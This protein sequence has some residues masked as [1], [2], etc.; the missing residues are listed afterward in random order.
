MSQLTNALNNI[1]SCEYIW[2]F[3]LWVFTFF[4]SLEKILGIHRIF[5]SFSAKRRQFI[6]QVKLRGKVSYILYR[7]KNAFLKNYNKNSRY[8]VFVWYNIR[9]TWRY[10]CALVP[11]Q[12]LLLSPVLI[13]TE[14][15]NV[16]EME[17]THANIADLFLHYTWMLAS[18]LLFRILCYNFLTKHF[19]AYIYMIFFP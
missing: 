10:L 6:S 12:C 9:T 11:F 19:R 2:N 18:S 3:W 16:I 1:A 13:N 7:F 5:L 4:T 14:Q 17:L 8:Q 15:T